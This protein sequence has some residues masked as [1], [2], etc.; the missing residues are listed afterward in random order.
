MSGKW[1]TVFLC[2]MV[3]TVVMEMAAGVL[4]YPWLNI[5]VNILAAGVVIWLVL[6]IRNFMRNG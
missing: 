2:I 4:S 5:A 1:L 3:F 6:I